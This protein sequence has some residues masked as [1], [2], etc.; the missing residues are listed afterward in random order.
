VSGI[1]RLR[2]AGKDKAE[3]CLLILTHLPATHTGTKA[4]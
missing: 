1:N 2:N 3:W 4:V